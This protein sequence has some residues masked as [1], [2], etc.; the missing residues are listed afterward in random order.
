MLALNG[1]IPEYGDRRNWVPRNQSDYGDGGAYPEVRILQYPLGMGR[2]DKKTKSNAIALQFDGDGKVKYDLIAR[3][4]H[5]KD[6]IV[7]SKL[8]DL[9][10]NE[11]LDNDRAL[12]KPADD[13]VQELTEK[14]RQALQKLTNSKIA[15]A[16]PVRCAAKTGPEQFIRYTQSEQ[17]SG[18]GNG[19]TKQRIIRL[20]EAQVRLGFYKIIKFEKK[21][22]NFFK[23]K[24]FSKKAHL[25][26]NFF[27]NDI[28][29]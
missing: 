15:A 10:P 25:D 8:S 14:T 18:E 21:T 23:N 1:S 5:A 3:Q 26:F 7:Y 12:E 17:N 11:V 29:S 6:R 19:E 9:L 20:V 16:L 2:P 4:G 22:I 24:H 28:S 27:T 13:D